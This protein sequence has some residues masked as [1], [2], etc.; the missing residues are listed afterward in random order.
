MATLDLSVEIPAGKLNAAIVL[1]SYRTPWR[2][3]T[4]CRRFAY[5]FVY[6][7]QSSL[8]RP[9]E[10]HGRTDIARSY[11]THMLSAETSNQIPREQ[12]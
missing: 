6:R 1:H 11:E 5:R 7:A 10:A 2:E 9:I 12:R 4:R 8:R 3:R